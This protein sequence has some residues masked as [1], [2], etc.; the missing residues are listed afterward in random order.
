MIV[1]NDVPVAVTDVTLVGTVH[2]D[3]L[4][5][6]S[7]GNPEGAPGS[8]PTSVTF[9][10]AQLNAAVLVGA[11][12]DLTYAFNSVAI[13]GQPTGISS[14]GSP[15]TFDVVGN[16]IVGVSADSRVVF[17]LVN[18]GN[19]TFTFTLLD[20]VDH[21]PLN[22]GTGDAELLGLSL[23]NVFVATDSDGDTVVL[24]GAVTLNIENDVPVANVEASANAG[25]VY[26]DGLS[27]GNSEAGHT[28]TSVTI[29][30]AQLASFVAVGADEGLTF[31]LNPDASTI[32]SG[33]TSGGVPVTY[34]VSGNTLT[35]SAGADT[36]F[37][38]VN[39]GDLTFTFTLLGA[40]DHGPLN[41]GGGDEETLA[42]NLASLFTATDFDGDSV[43]LSGTVLVTVENDIPT[44][45]GNA[46]VQLDEDALANGNLGGS[47]DFDPL[48][49]GPVTAN[50]A[51][52]HQYG[53]DEPG[54]IKLTGVT[55]P[56]GLDFTSVVTDTLITVKQ[57]GVDVLTIA[58][59]DAEAGTYT[60]TQLAAI[61]HTQGPNGEDNLQFTV[62][63]T[64]TDFDGDTATGSLTVDVDDDTPDLTSVTF[65][66]SQTMHDETAGV[67]NTAADADVTSLPGD[68]DIENDVTGPLTVF[69]DWTGAGEVLAG[70]GT[71][72]GYAQNTS[73]AVVSVPVGAYGAD[74]AG[75]APDLAADDGR[76]RQLQRYGDQPV[77]YRHRQSHLPLHGR[78]ERSRRCP[79]G[80]RNGGRRFQPGRRDLVCAVARGQWHGVDRS[81]PRDRASQH[82][83]ARRVRDVAELGRRNGASVRDGI[84]RRRR[85]GYRLQDLIRATDRQVRRRRP[86]GGHFAQ[87]SDDHSR[88]DAPR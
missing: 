88:R 83:G 23:A 69:T 45:S 27:T 85:R 24:S 35:A 81:I 41:I 12:D 75:A 4:T 32:A 14:H 56:A 46:T 76:G 36:I 19:Q 70:A 86:D 6:L 64:A 58:L 16:S 34:S 53:A 66:L 7:I 72:I 47:G 87:L 65:T 54:S 62:D 18:N 80:N 55:L 10:A 28:A 67:Q 2:E 33:L 40:L 5:G 44:V 1:E 73:A 3:S 43:V 17:T 22:S 31:S 82:D 29:S 21:L 68:L 51:L 71:A 42:L 63:Y 48:T 61:D 77:R 8:Q 59:N 60:V 11:D 20:Q 26:E 38:L 25:I 13:D 9:G 15:V 37:T 78:S 49:N 30:T 84:G 79:R 74:G 57:H 52:S 50:G 39:N